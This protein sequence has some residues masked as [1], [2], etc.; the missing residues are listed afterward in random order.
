M[1]DVFHRIRAVPDCPGHRTAI[2][3]LDGFLSAGPY[4]LVC[5]LNPK[6]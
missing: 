6:Q 5:L 1:M 3:A 2:R 4:Y